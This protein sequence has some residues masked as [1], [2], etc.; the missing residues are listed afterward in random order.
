M[1]FI[2]TFLKGD[3]NL[4]RGFSHSFSMN[5]YDHKIFIDDMQQHYLSKFREDCV[6]TPWN[7]IV[8]IKN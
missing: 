4:M 6:R 8:I 2:L 5:L 1:H 3:T 7:M